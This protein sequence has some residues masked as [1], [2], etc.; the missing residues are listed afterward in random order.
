MLKNTEDRSHVETVLPIERIK[1]K[2]KERVYLSSLLSIIRISTFLAPT[3]LHCLAVD[4]CVVYRYDGVRGRFL[5]RKPEIEEEG[6]L[7]L[8]LVLL[9]LFQR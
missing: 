2:D 4:I 9:C 7:S 5:G 6:D 8:L 1:V 3:A